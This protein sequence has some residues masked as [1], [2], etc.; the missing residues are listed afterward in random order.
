MQGTLHDS[1]RPEPF[2]GGCTRLGSILPKQK[3]NGLNQV[4]KIKC[5]GNPAGCSPCQ[6]AQHIC[7]TTDRNNGRTTVRGH[8]DRLEWENRDLQNRLAHLERRL[9]AHGI[10]IE[11]APPQQL[12]DT[13]AA[14]ANQGHPYGAQ[15]PEDED[16]AASASV[17][18]PSLSILKGTTLELFGMQIDVAKFTRAHDDPESPT[19]R[20]TFLKYTFGKAHVD[21]VPALPPTLEEAQDMAVMYLKS[22]NPFTP[23]LHK[24]DLFPALTRLYEG[25]RVTAA[26][27]VIIHMFFGEMKY[28]FALRNQQRQLMDQAYAHYKYSLGFYHE[29]LLSRK[30]PD[31][32]A[33][34]L[35]AVKQRNF[36]KPGA[37]WECA[38]LVLSL[39]IELDLHRSANS[40]PE[41]ER[42]SLTYHQ[43]EMRKR[44]FW[45]AYTLSISLSWKLGL[46]IR[47]KTEDTDIE[48]PDPEPDD[49]LDEPDS[50]SFQ[51]GIAAIRILE[52]T[53]R[54]INSL[55]TPRRSHRRYANEMPKFENEILE[56]RKSLR[57]DLRDPS[58]ASREG[59]VQAL[60]IHFWQI[61]ALFFLRHPV[62][63]SSSDPKLNAENSRIILD[64]ASDMLG[65][66]MEMRMLNC[67]DVPWINC[68]VYLAAVFTTLFIHEQNSEEIS[69]AELRKLEADMGRWLIVLQAIGKILGKTLS[70]FCLFSLLTTTRHR[71]Q[72]G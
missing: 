12:W 47:L 2:A 65:V 25:R 1:V 54:M 3:A 61:E 68:T 8:A 36:P 57:P 53:S 60:F 42:E 18:N 15:Y 24:P 31:L 17:P 33:L 20:E 21:T 22:L 49:L 4:R 40:L 71:R 37:A 50:C 58:L 19:G 38:Q 41:E 59:K 6:Q 9:R 34:L 48:F 23:I 43:K 44:I 62:I 10:P 14:G 46:P 28:Q 29:L 64:L 69:S 51:V 30:I 26:E 5:D 11:D 45:I 39:A 67:I 55:F 13:A 72:L 63:H 52:I 35:I 32:Q 16:G 70:R 66:V 7:K 56:W 27:E